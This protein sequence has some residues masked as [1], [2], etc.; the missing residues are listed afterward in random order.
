MSALLDEPYR[1]YSASVWCTLSAK[2]RVKHE[3]LATLRNQLAVVASVGILCSLSG[4]AKERASIDRVQANALRKSF[5]VGE[6]LENTSDDP[7]FYYW[8]TIVDVDYGAAQSGLFTSNSAQSVARIKWVIQE[9]FLLAR[10]TYELI[11]DSSGRGAGPTSSDGTVVA[12]FAIE[13]HFDIQREY[14]PSTGEALNIISENTTDRH[15]YEREY[16]RVDW[17]TNHSVDTYDFDLLAAIGITDGV[18]YT[19]LSL[20]ETDPA[21][22]DRPVFEADYFD[23]TTRAFARPL[24]VDLSHLGWGVDKIP[25]CLLPIDLGGG[26]PVATCNPTELTIRHSFRRVVP[27]DY[28]P[29]DWDGRR[30][31]A[32]GAFTTER[33]GFDPFYGVVD[34]K[35]RRFISRYNIWER[36]HYYAEPSTMTGGIGCNTPESTP[37][38][39]DP[40]RDVD[41]DGTADECE[42]AGAGSQCDVFNRLCTLPY[43]QREVK[44]IVWY[45][46]S[47]SD[48]EFFDATRE[49]TYQW[50]TA[51]RAAVLAA[52][53]SECIRAD[54]SRE[55]CTAQYPIYFGQQDQHED[56]LALVAEVSRCRNDQT[57]GDTDCSAQAQS[58]ANA[59]G[60]DSA[61]VALALSE[62]MVILCHSPVLATDPSECG[63]PGTTV[64]PGDLRYHQINVVPTPQVSAPWGVYSDA[65]DPLTGETIA[66]SI[67]VWSHA[68]EVWSRQVIDQMR[69][70]EGEL[71]AEDITEGRHV[72]DWVSAARAPSG[73]ALPMLTRADLDSRL[74]SVARVDVDHMRSA[75]HDL[76]THPGLLQKLRMQKN[77]ISSIRADAFAVSTMAS[78]YDQRRS[79]CLGSPTE[80]ELTTTAMGALSGVAALGPG[81]EVT[82]FASPLRGVNVHLHGRFEQARN[83]AV[84]R[85]GDCIRHEAPA[86]SSLTGLSDILQEKFGAFN[87]QDSAAAQEERAERMRRYIAQR[88]HTSVV[89]HEMGHSLGLRHNFVSSSD[90]FNYRPQYWQLRTRNGAVT[91]ECTDLASDGDTCIG[92]RFFDPVSPD[93]RDNLIWMFMHSSVMDYAGESTQDMMGLGAYDFAAVK[94]FYGDVVSVYSDDSYE[95][96]TTRSRFVLSK[97]DNFGGILGFSWN[98][99][100]RT[101]NRTNEIHYSQLNRVFDLIDDCRSVQVSAFEPSSWNEATRGAWHPVFDGH[102]VSVDGVSSRC[103]TQPVDFVSWSALTAADDADVEGFNVGNPGID[104]SGRVRVPY[105]FATDRWADLGNLAVFTYDN[106]ADSYELFNFL[107]AEQETNHIFDNYRRRRQSFSVRQAVERT[108]HRYNAKLRDAAK[109]LGLLANIYRDFAVTERFRFSELWPAIVGTDGTRYNG[110]AVNALASGLAFDHFARQLQRPASGEHFRDP[111]RPVLRS[112]NDTLT[113][114]RLPEVIVPNGVVGYYDSVGIGGRPVENGL[115]DENGDYN[116]DY[117]VNAGSYYEKIYTAML[118]T[119][120]VD[121]FISDSRR[122]FTDPRYRAVSLA[123]LFPDGYRRWLA[124]NLTN[125]HELTG[126]FV[127]TENGRPIIDAAQYPT[128]PI[129]FTSWW[130]ESP[131][132]CFPDPSSIVCSAFAAP[133]EL[134]GGTSTTSTAQY[135]ALDPQVSWE[136][137]KFLIAW[138]LMYLPENEQRWWLDQMGIWVIGADSDPGFANRIEFHNPAG[139]V[140]VAR[141]YGKETIFGKVVQK[142]VGARILEYANELLER[143]YVVT[144][145][146]DLDGDGSPDWYVPVFAEGEP[147]VKYDRAV[148]S[149]LGTF[150]REGCNESS[151]AECACDENLACIE[152]SRYVAV[153]AFMRQALRD[154]G[155]A[156]PSMRGLR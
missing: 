95:L 134:Y 1:P 50:D 38:G 123:D 128:N 67:N 84:A 16:M 135:I 33:T 99:G 154:F 72:R 13:S 118:M 12:A 3:T 83:L 131:E 43:R 32:F 57:H 156:D 9:D 19:P 44:P 21:S 146:P 107:I 56:A 23:V 96:G 52:H 39:S 74:A 153:P 125:D 49:A 66:S 77:A 54:G 151:N 29:A 27:T 69:F 105:G 104:P 51:M 93:E 115:S 25:A 22:P 36:S 86:P 106:G 130:T 31:Q 120:S 11:D 14:N 41:S 126:A 114:P 82:A 76:D 15:W 113:L 116:S 147:I 127:R 94:M 63:D 137:H 20:D 78:T 148:R 87:R 6:D 138:T 30:F 5:F 121:N 35:W 91:Q 152:L 109:G 75:H 97:L 68:T 10:L 70:L 17:S 144:D 26:A 79:Q 119:E 58:I 117:T 65:H 59:R 47:G 62:P 136:Q 129:G 24:T 145:G 81:S 53:Y 18:E 61:I 48:P 45:Y 55:A 42:E 71:S 85:R 139:D 124:N 102:I 100:T 80:A 73:G 88:A 141:T 46:T 40:N 34:D 103:R 149:L 4:C 92:P 122:D 111:L 110:V 90:A 64:R 101:G 60:Y 155:L 98:D 28:V 7:E 112:T 8:N 150:G 108:H 133:N 2:A 140:M 37:F 142:G 132:V 89:L 143:A